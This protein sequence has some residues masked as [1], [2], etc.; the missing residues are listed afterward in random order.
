[1]SKRLLN[2][3]W[4]YIYFDGVYCKQSLPY[5]SNTTLTKCINNILGDPHW[6]I[7]DYRMLKAII[8]MLPRHIYEYEWDYALARDDFIAYDILAS[9][10]GNGRAYKIHLYDTTN[11]FYYKIQHRLCMRDICNE[12]L[13]GPNSST[14]KEAKDNFESTIMS[15]FD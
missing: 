5:L 4:N 13:Y 15:S 7:Y 9:K 12:L 3:D 14:Y 6:K 8:N 2:G 11:K 1:M 10:P